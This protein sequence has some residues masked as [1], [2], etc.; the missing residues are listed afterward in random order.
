[1]RFSKDTINFPL[2][3]RGKQVHLFTIYPEF[4]GQAIHDSWFTS[5]EKAKTQKNNFLT[6]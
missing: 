2:E 5:Y 6:S 1:M 4:S 3:S